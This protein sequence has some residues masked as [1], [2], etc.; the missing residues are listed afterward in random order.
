MAKAQ[1]TRETQDIA[2]FRRDIREKRGGEHYYVTLLGFK[3][4]EISDL[5][6]RVETG[7]NFN[8]FERFKRNVD[9]QTEDLA[10]LLQIRLRTLARRREKG[11]FTADESDR[12]L[13]VSRVFGKALALFEGNLE[14][15]RTWLSTPAPA[16]AGR[17]PQD[18][19]T[20]EVGAREVE[21]LIGRLEHGVF[22]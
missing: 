16:L 2:A 18:L 15:A 11:R 7:F 17:T 1:R 9:L 5:L 8:T 21:N 20:T 13:R 14:A 4:Q 19:S 6:K 12:L 22:S 10:H 3:T